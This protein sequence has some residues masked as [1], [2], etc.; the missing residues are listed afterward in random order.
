MH[1]EMLSKPSQDSEGVVYTPKVEV[2]LIC[3]I[4]L[5][6]YILEGSGSELNQSEKS[7]LRK[8]RST[9]DSALLIDLLFSPNSERTPV[10][11]QG[12][13]ILKR[14]L[15]GVRIIDPACGAG[16]FLV[17][18]LL[19]LIE[20]LEKLGDQPD[21]Q[22][23]ANLVQHCI[24]GA[25]LDDLAIRL[26]EF[27]LWLVIAQGDISP[28]RQPV[29]PNLGLNLIVGDSIVQLVNKNYF[30]L[31]GFRGTFPA[32][33]EEPLN[34]L[35]QL[36]QQYF[37]G[38]SLLLEEIFHEKLALIEEYLKVQSQESPNQ[39][40]TSLRKDLP[41]INERL[42]LWDVC[43]SH[44]MLR[45]GFDVAVVNPPYVRSEQITGDEKY[46]QQLQAYVQTYH[47]KTVSGRSDLYL[48]FFFKTLE[49]LNSRGCFVFITSN[50]WLDVDFGHALQEKL[51]D[52]TEL[53]I[54]LEFSSNRVF[55]DSLINTIITAGR[56]RTNRAEGSTLFLTIKEQREHEIF[57]LMKDAFL[58]M[59][60][61]ETF[62]VSGVPVE[63]S[64]NTQIKRVAIKTDSLSQIGVGKWGRLLRAP[65]QF[66][67]LSERTD[68]ILSPLGK[69]AKVKRGLT[70]GANEFFY[71][72]SPGSSNK[73]FR[74]EY[75]STT[76]SLFLHILPELIETFQKQG[77]IPKSPMF[78]IET[79]Y[80][81]HQVDGDES[82]LR[83]IY[84]VIHTMNNSIWVPNYVIKGPKEIASIQVTPRKMK[85]VVLLAHDPPDHL[86]KGIQEYV[87]WGEEF[88]PAIGGHYPHR[89]TCRSRQLWYN[90][91][92]SSPPELLWIKGVWERHM[93]AL[94]NR[95]CYI[96]QQIYGIYLEDSSLLYTTLGFLNS[97]LAALFA[98]LT[99]RSN[100][101]EGVLWTATYEAESTPTLNEPNSQIIESVQKILSK[102]V[103][104]IL[105]DIGSRNPNKINVNE[106]EPDRR[107]L[108]SVIMDRILGL[109]HQE[110]L[111]V[112]RNVVILVTTRLKKAKVKP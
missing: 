95:M 63:L 82:E 32:H 104:S 99:G 26:T 16:A 72:P 111:Q 76:G 98:E 65:V 106:V 69:I 45:G 87:R 86:E 12:K 84:G 105:D 36:K 28:L 38:D 9:E 64:E 71:L 25:D 48:Y 18:M 83:Q 109:N 7:E 39:R 27:R 3:R 59:S 100:L 92:V 43:F 79:K 30:T 112:Y 56:K 20:L 10:E 33:L 81:M 101:G 94:C 55:H 110:Q 85:Y 47:N 67:E 66:F 44:I 11:L 74:A 31:S 108:D 107:A 2:D 62:V 78:R 8:L 54:L 89:S 57:Q 46:K 17:G 80:W 50:S 14:L 88:E 1:R 60:E 24:H 15:K 6:N 4:A 73:F 77:F 102:P 19:L 13:T 35:K 58:G 61:T 103:S 34:K 53:R 5:Y 21:C 70:T 49:T 42:F 97:T 29:L 23:R 90:L 75:D 41:S 96:D 40:L 37:S 91:G 68:N 93:V 52:C 51:L 22:T